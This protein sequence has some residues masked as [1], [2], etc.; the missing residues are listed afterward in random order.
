MLVA[1]F[2]NIPSKP[3]L[4]SQNYLELESL[5]IDHKSYLI[6]KFNNDVLVVS[7]IVHFEF[8][9]GLVIGIITGIITRIITRI[10]T[11]IAI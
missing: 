10:I 3:L 1:K 9:I 6:S 2:T 8:D 4:Y 5:I 11:G 7:K